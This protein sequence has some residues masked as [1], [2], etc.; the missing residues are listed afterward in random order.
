[1]GNKFFLD[2]DGKHITKLRAWL[3]LVNDQHRKGEHIVPLFI[4]GLV[5]VGRMQ[6]SAV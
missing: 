4:N 1:M 2:P 3:Q 6:L 5:K